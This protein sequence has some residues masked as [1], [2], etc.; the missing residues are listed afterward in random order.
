MSYLLPPFGAGVFGAAGAFGA[1]VVPAFG[2]A[3]AAP[4]FS[5][6]VL[7]GTFAAAPP[8]PVFGSAAG[9]GV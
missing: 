6:G 2:V 1:G 3:G 8:V 4:L 7:P 9:D 5:L